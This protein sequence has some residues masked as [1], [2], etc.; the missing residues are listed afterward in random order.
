MS[1]IILKAQVRSLNMSE[2]VDQK[3][4]LMPSSGHFERKLAEK[5]LQ[6]GPFSVYKSTNMYANYEKKSDR[7]EI[8][9]NGRRKHFEFENKLYEEAI[10]TP[11]KKTRKQINFENNKSRFWENSGGGAGGLNLWKSW[12]EIWGSSLSL[13]F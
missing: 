1:S 11:T 10:S 4:T 2:K 12:R 6:H 8:T 3:G 9:S 5:G 7:K 13:F